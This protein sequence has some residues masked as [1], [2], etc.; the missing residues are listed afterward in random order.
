MK[1]LA[2]LTVKAGTKIELPAT[3]TGK[4]EPKITWTKADKLLKQDNRITIE[5]VPN[6]STVTI[7]DS[8]RSDTG[9]YIIEAVNACGRATAVVEVNVLGKG[10]SCFKNR[11]THSSYLF[12][13]NILNDFLSACVMSSI[14]KPGPPA[15]FDITEVTNE[16]CLLTWN[17]PRDDGGSKVTNYVVERK[18]TD[19]DMWHKLSST[20]K[21]TNFKATKLTPNKEYLF[22][23][24][25][26]N[27]YGVGEP[28]QAAPI[29][30]KF[31]FGK[32]LNQWGGGGGEGCLCQTWI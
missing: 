18:A 13:G 9:T 26:E 4:P 3:V 29:T 20:V 21:D 30:A 23:V 28:V 12:K 25:A 32:F 8:K 2:G 6:K 17:P 15:A 11:Q 14:D 10:G 27:M 31:Q 19:S 5:N 7:V 24:A 16:S 1:L 22:R